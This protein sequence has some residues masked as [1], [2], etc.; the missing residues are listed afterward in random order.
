MACSECGEKL[1]RCIN[2]KYHYKNTIKSWCDSEY[3][4]DWCSKFD[5]STDKVIH[6]LGKIKCP[7][8]ELPDNVN[9]CKTCGR[10]LRE[11]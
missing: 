2:C 10:P 3:V 1:H 7:V 4:Y 5:Q 9:F 6:G 11:D 8:W